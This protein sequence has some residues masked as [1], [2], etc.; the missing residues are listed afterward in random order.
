MAND[1]RGSA[2]IDRPIEQVFAFL[3]DGTNDPKFSPRVQEIEK[4]TDG[5]VGAGTVF[6]STVKDAGMKTQ[7]EFE[8][9][10]FE[11]PTRIRWTERSQNSITVPSGGYDL[12]REGDGT[13]LTISNEF[14]GHGFGKLI[15]PLALRAARRDAEAIAGRIKAAVEAE[16]PA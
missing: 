10:E 5:P 6:T 12:E 13:R 3:A 4:R 16:A 15:L 7:R 8:L 11:E 9:T 14:E 2:V 1:F